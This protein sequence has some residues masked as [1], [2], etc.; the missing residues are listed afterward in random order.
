MIGKM[1]RHPDKYVR[2]NA[3]WALSRLGGAAKPLLSELCSLL[4]DADPRTAAGAAQ[5]IGS[6]GEAAATAVPLLA[7]AMRGTNIV[8]CRLAAK[9][10][11][12]V[13]QPALVTLI[14][15][16]RHTDPFVRGEAAVALGW[17]GAIAAPAVN[18]LIEVA[19]VGATK[20]R[21]NRPNVTAQTPPTGVAA[22]PP[23]DA[24]EEALY[25]N[26]LIALGRIGPDAALALP[27]L[28]DALF[29]DCEAVRRAAEVAI[30][31]I[32]GV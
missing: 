10:L 30:R 31:Q 17:L 26:V 1:L 32:Q 27:F 6:M 29:D 2:R 14:Q 15:H 13:G 11:S 22:T 9:S 12:Q 28:Q 24:T 3:V 20:R 7:E 16:L 21:V 23:P 19:R 4:K 18:A 8:L 5:A 25:T